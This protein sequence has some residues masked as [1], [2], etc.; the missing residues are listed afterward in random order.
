MFFR[1]PERRQ[2]N[3]IPCTKLRPKSYVEEYTE[4]DEIHIVA[5][6]RVFQMHPCSK[7]ENE[8]SVKKSRVKKIRK[9]SEFK[10]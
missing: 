8:V 10:S 2:P 3:K 6:I 5:R 9:K 4:T 1:H 7:L